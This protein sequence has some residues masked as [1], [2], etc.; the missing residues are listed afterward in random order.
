M[1]STPLFLNYLEDLEGYSDAEFGRLLRALL[2]YV[3]D[4][5]EPTLRR[6][7]T[8]VWPLLRSNADR[9]RE[10]YEKLCAQRSLAGTKG[11]EARWGGDKGM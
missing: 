6:R 9:A 1:K 4:G 2:R 3:R 5:G 8:L 10:Q 7:E 11:A